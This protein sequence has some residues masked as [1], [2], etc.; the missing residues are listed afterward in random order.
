MASEGFPEKLSTR[1]LP[2]LEA[3]SFGVDRMLTLAMKK[4]H[5]L[6]RQMTLNVYS[7]CAMAG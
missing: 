7:A 3:R 2:I 5:V 6:R 1:L 4:I